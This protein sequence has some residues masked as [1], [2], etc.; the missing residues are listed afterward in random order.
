MPLSCARGVS[1]FRLFYFHV[2]PWKAKPLVGDT[3]QS[4]E[5]RRCFP[6]LPE[7][8]NSEEDGVFEENSSCENIE[9]SGIELAHS[10]VVCV[11][12]H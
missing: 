10:P 11:G 2:D 5:K 9:S 8:Q 3:R 7:K 4:C 1:S 6:A 12:Q